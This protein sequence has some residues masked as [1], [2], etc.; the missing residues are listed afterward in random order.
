MTLSQRQPLSI[1]N[2]QN[3]IG[4]CCRRMAGKVKGMEDISEVVIVERT[5]EIKCCTKEKQNKTHG[6]LE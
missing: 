5:L 3:R 2:G 4:L 1:L 6:C